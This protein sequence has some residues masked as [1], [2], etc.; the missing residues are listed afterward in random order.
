[1]LHLHWTFTIRF[2]FDGLCVCFFWYMYTHVNIL[3]GSFPFRDLSF[4]PKYQQP[5][6]PTTSLTSYPSL[7]I[8]H[9]LKK[10]PLYF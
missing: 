7:M 2:T 5:S 1:M 10:K 3:D 4:S 9:I 6:I 8:T